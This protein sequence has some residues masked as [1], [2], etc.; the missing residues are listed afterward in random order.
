MEL[1][2]QKKIEIDNAINKFLAEIIKKYDLVK[3]DGELISPT[4]L[5]ERF[6]FSEIVTEEMSKISVKGSEIEG[7]IFNYLAE[8]KGEVINKIISEYKVK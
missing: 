5:L 2:M 1:T 4:T 6:K 3:S 7:E 8:K